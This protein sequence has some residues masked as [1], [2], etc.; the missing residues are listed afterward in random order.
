MFDL[1]ALGSVACIVVLF[2]GLCAV[3]LFSAIRI[4]PEYQR[5][6]ILRLG[7]YVGRERGPGLLLPRATPDRRVRVLESQSGEREAILDFTPQ[8]PAARDAAP[9][10]EP[11]GAEI[12]HGRHG[13]DL[14]LLLRDELDIAQKP[15]LAA[16]LAADRTVESGTRS[17]PFPPFAIDAL[18]HFFSPGC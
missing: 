9:A 15:V 13:C 2:V 1:G 14:D 5:L 4:V 8:A 6:V 12:G 11:A 10:D 17:F 7:R 16:T 18:T 3:V